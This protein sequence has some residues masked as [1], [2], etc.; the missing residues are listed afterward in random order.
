MPKDQEHN[1]EAKQI[2]EVV[3]K[4]ATS[5]VQE[6][7]N[8]YRKKYT[9]PV[10]NIPPYYRDLFA[11]M[12]HDDDSIA[13]AAYDKVLFER[14]LAVPHLCDQYELANQKTAEHRKLRYYSIQLIAFSGVRIGKD[15]VLHALSDE[16][17]SVRKEALYAVEDLKIK[18]AIPLVRERLQDLNTEVRRV[19]QE[20]YDYLLSL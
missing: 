2:H 11:A 13:N 12:L 20:V 18:S 3:E 9:Q 1:H 4:N 15:T 5:N 10:N 14:G 16:C 6:N 7:D 19:A 17:Y 8:T